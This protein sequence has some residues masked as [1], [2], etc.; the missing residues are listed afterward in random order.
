M[1]YY[2]IV[3]VDMPTGSTDPSHPLRSA[4]EPPKRQLGDFH[5][6]LEPSDSLGSNVSNLLGWWFQSI[7]FVF[8]NPA[9]RHAKS[10]PGTDPNSVLLY[11]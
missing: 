2:I 10:E 7:F 8:R 1:I 11:W 3:Y 9:H 5:Q 4:K 6:G